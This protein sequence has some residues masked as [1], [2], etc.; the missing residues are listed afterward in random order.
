MVND[1]SSFRVD[2][3]DRSIGERRSFP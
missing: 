1:A 3:L 2:F